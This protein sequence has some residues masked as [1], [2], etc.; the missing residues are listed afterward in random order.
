MVI[1][2][3]VNFCNNINWQWLLILLFI[4]FAI[5]GNNLSQHLL[6]LKDLMAEAKMKYIGFNL[7]MHSI[8]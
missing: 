2:S 1:E 3:F 4:I 5:T 7:M 8:S 6:D